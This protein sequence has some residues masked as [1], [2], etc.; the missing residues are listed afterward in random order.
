MQLLGYGAR[1]AKLAHAEEER[2]EYLSAILFLK[3]HRSGDGIHN[4]CHNATAGC[5]GACYDTFGRGLFP[6]VNASR[7]R[8]T[9]EFFADPRGFVDR[10]KHDI[11]AGIRRA[12]RE[13]REFCARLNGTSDIPWEKIRGSN[14]LTV[15]EQFDGEHGDPWTRFWDYSKDR[16]RVMANAIPNLH[17]TFSAS[18][19]TTAAEIDECIAAGVSCAVVM[20]HAKYDAPTEWRSHRC[21][22]GDAHDFRW[23]DT[24]NAY[25]RGVIVA[26]SAKGRA[27]QDTTG[28]R[29]TA[30]TRVAA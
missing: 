30:E 29:H 28:F 12:A 15:Y 6:N 3:P 24:P 22:D 9:R 8:K 26:L 7:T 13:G 4:T 23:L 10:L 1:S 17:L 11:R 27:R 19:L 2:P 21:V 25:P 14:G 5:A 20:D 16:A 18:E